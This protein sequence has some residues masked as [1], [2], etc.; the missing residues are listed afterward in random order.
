M[1]LGILVSIVSN[2]DIFL[3][4]LGVVALFWILGN[5]IIPLFE[6]PIPSYPQTTREIRLSEEHHADATG[7]IGCEYSTA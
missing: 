2:F 7:F 4:I 3:Q 6:K 5:V 1:V